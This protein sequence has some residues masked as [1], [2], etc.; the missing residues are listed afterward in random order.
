MSYIRLTHLKEKKKK[1][2][3]HQVDRQDLKSSMPSKQMLGILESLGRL[4]KLTTH[5]WN[6]QINRLSPLAYIKFVYQ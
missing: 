5:Q 4:S 6:K 3:C 2:P 1:K